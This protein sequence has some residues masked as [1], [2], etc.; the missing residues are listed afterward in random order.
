LLAVELKDFPA[1]N[2]FFDLALK[3][4]PK[5]AAEVLVTW[6][7]ELFVANQFADAVKVFQRGLDETLLPAN[8]PTLHFYLASALE[9]SGQTDDAIEAARKAADL[10]A[11]SPRFQSRVAWIQYHAKRNEAARQS[12]QAL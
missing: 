2:T 11:D 10:Q 5:K 6:G 4:E 8:N 1:A 7:L 9:M 3:A 12:Y